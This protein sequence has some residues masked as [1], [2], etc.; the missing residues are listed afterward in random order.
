MKGQR[1][2]GSWDGKMTRKWLKRDIN[3]AGLSPFSVEK[4]V[5]Q[6][7]A[8]LVDTASLLIWRELVHI[9]ASSP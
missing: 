4:I 8:S 1:L 3:V 7:P 2:Q 6:I 9:Q 5:Q